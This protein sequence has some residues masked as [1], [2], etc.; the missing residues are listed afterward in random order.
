MLTQMRHALFAMLLI[1]SLARGAFAQ[2]AAEPDDEGDEA[3]ME[4]AEPAAIGPDVRYTTDISD[5]DL[6][7]RWE[8]ELDA[9]GS[10]SV[11][12]ADKGRLINAEQMPDDPAWMR[13]RPDLSF[14]AQETIEA[15]SAAF[16]AVHERF[17]D[18]A[19]ARLS[20]ISAHDGGYLRPHRS[21][22]SGRDADIGFF[23]KNDAVP[24]RGVSRERLMDPERNWALLRALI[25]LTDVQVIL[26][27]RKIQ[28]VLKKHALAAGEDRAWIDRVFGKVVQHA[29][30]HKDHFH[31]RF[32]APRSQEL[33]R[34]IQPLL[35]LR[36]EQNVALHKVRSGQTLGHIAILYGTTVAL[37]RGANHMRGSSFLR[38]GQQLSVPLR[39]PCTKCPLPPPVVVPA[40]CLPLESAVATA[41]P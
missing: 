18:S 27:D 13:Q 2:Q 12:F 28:Q 41:T 11:G 33:G 38:L 26:V 16:R 32:F 35:A 40:R 25:T 29:R 24:G 6:Q 36:P 4:S 10:I 5:E 1:G 17:P 37:I 20:Q 31:V 22:Q 21:H 8:Q 23:Y 9:L 7:R 15:L 19:P 30:R 39:K 3:E 34:R 14:G